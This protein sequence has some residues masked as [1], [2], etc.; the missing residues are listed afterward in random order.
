VKCTESTPERLRI[1]VKTAAA[2]LDAEKLAQL[3]QAVQ[4]LGQKPTARKARGSPGSNQTLT[5][6][7]GGTIG[8]KS[9]VRV[10]SEFWIELIRDVTPELV[11][12]NTLPAAPA[13]QYTGNV[14]STPCSMWKTT[15]P[16]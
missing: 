7:M 4:S 16:T 15:R 11:V 9:T 10:G 3:F 14:K 5:E 6:L 8:V 2:G 12:E 13:L 1:S